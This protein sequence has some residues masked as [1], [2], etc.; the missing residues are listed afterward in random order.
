GLHTGT[1]CTGESCP[2]WQQLD[3]NPKSVGIAATETG[4][5]Q[6]HHDGWIWR[7]TGTPCSGSSCPGWQRPDNNPPTGMIAGGDPVYHLQTDP[8][9]Q[10][11]NDGWIW[12]YTDT[13]CD[14]EFCPG[15]QRLD[16]NGNTVEIAAAGSQLFQRHRDGRI[17]RYTG[18][19]CSGDSCASWQL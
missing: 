4:V 12:R 5:F 2:G 14:G 16:N 6:L 19:P 9:Y 10:L 11:H 13:E 15:W 3:N 8:L 7:Y 18:T 1:P 17:W